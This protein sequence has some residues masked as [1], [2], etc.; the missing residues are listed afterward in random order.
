MPIHE[1]TDLTYADLTGEHQHRFDSSLC[2]DRERR[3]ICGTEAAATSKGWNARWREEKAL[4]A[5]RDVHRAQR[6][7]ASRAALDLAPDGGAEQV[8]PVQGQVYG[9]DW[10]DGGSLVLSQMLEDGG[11]SQLW[12]LAYPS[13]A[14]MRLTNDL[15]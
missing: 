2:C 5:E 4:A 9:L 11:P 6:Q 15:E 13:G 14:M 12:R 8:L 3:P 10:L 1:A 7:L